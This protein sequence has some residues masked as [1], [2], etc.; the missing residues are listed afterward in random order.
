LRIVRPAWCRAHGYE[1]AHVTLYR[2]R[3]GSR[4]RSGRGGVLVGDA[5]HINNPLGGT[6]MNGIQTPST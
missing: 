2:V 6:G 4:R 5:A 3:S 1:I